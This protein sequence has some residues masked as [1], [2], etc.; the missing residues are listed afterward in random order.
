[1]LLFLLLLQPLA[2]VPFFWSQDLENAFVESKEEIIHQY[3]KGVRL[4]DL[5]APV[6]LA[7]D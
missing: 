4:F 5:T 2:Q 6:G 7:T 3:E 1:M